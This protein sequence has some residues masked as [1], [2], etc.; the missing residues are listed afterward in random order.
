MPKVVID[1]PPAEKV[2]MAAA[3]AI[4]GEVGVVVGAKALQVAQAAQ[5]EIVSARV[6]VDP[7][8][9]VVHPVPE[10]IFGDGRVVLVPDLAPV[11]VL[12]ELSDAAGVTIRPLTPTGPQGPP[13]AIG[14]D[15]Q[16]GR[17]RG[18]ELAEGIVLVQLPLGR[19]TEAG[20]V[21]HWLY[22]VFED[23]EFLGYTWSPDEVVDEAAGTVTIPMPVSE[24]QGTLFLPASLTPGFVANHDPL[25]EMWS[26]PT[27][28]ARGFG[29]AG[30]QF[31]TF[32]VVA[33]QVRER[34]FVYSPVVQN[35][36]WID[37]LSV[38]PVGPPES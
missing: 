24:L 17:A 3:L 35:Y 6:V 23:G 36:A 12:V 32:P 14:D 28:E 29:Y 27:K 37:A 9:T 33:P 16:D 20:A 38:G 21:F 8:P 30:P 31:T 4:R 15:P 5:P 22:E 13:A 18:L 26:G 10:R 34:L 2:V 11:D 7:A 25:A 1:V 19:P